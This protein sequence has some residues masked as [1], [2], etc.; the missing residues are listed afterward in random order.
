M[1]V[2][3]GGAKVCKISAQ[4]TSVYK[5]LKQLIHSDLALKTKRRG[6]AAACAIALQTIADCCGQRITY[7]RHS[8]NPA[9]PFANRPLL[10]MRN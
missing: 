8:S 4:K 9:Q 6:L 5:E 2:R 1:A 10:Y 3:F 7:K